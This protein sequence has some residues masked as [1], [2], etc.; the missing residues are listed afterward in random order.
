MDYEAIVIGAVF[1]AT[2]AAT[3]LAP[4]GKNGRVFD[5]GKPAG[6]TNM[7]PGLFVVDDSSIPGALVANPWLTIAAQAIEV[8][9]MASP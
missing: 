7:L 8:V 3:R 9:A 1:G 4:L 6:S 2:I 5:G